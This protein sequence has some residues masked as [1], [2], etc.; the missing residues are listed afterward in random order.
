MRILYS[1]LWTFFLE[2]SWYICPYYFCFFKSSGLS[3]LLLEPT[4]SLAQ[5]M[6]R[7]SRVNLVRVAAADLVLNPDSDIGLGE[8]S[9][10]SPRVYIDLISWIS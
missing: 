5:V 3:L 7:D 1:Y 2:R 10:T 8:G 9:L 6:L 4:L